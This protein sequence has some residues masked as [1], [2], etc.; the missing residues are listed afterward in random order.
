MGFSVIYL[1]VVVHVLLARDQVQSVKDWLTTFSIQHRI[2]IIPYQSASHRDGASGESGAASLLNLQGGNVE[3][4]H[5][6]TLQLVMV[7]NAVFRCYDFC[8][9]IGKIDRFV[10]PNVTFDNLHLGV[11]PRHD[12]ISW[13]WDLGFPTGSRDEKQVDRCVDNWI[14]GDINESSI[15]DESRV[16]SYKGMIMITGIAT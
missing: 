3:S 12:Q 11:R 9:C 14:F 2:D 15:A 16:Q 4:L 10:E 8:Y 7:D 1:S 6:L 5:A 13:M